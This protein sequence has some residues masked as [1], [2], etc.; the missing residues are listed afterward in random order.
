MPCGTRRRISTTTRGAARSGPSQR[1]RRGRREFYVRSSKR[2][3][4]D[5]DDVEKD[6]ATEP[7]KFNR[8]YEPGDIK[9]TMSI[10]SIET[11]IANSQLA[12]ALDYASRGIKV[13]P[14]HCPVEPRRVGFGSKAVI[15]CSC[16]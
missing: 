11:P 3:R 7:A 12:V 5:G 4:C 14:C 10:V 8:R 16:G 1:A 13:F 9:S 15:I 6:T 2:R